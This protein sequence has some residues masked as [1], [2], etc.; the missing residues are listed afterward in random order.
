MVGR[1]AIEHP[2]IFREANALL[3]EGKTLPP[4]TNE[5][6]LELCRAHL[7]ANVEERTEPY[8]VRCT[9][10]HLS[11]YLHGMRGASQLRQQLNSCDSLEGCLAILDS[12]AV[13]D[14]AAA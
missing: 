4:P 2:W 6:R 5:E 7:R 1:R 11:G 8:G 10:R 9:R 12:A 14:A 13:R 3:R